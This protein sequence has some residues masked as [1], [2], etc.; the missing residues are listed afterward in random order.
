MARRKGQVQP[1]QM[2]G[3]RPGKAPPQ[4]RKKMAKQQMGEL[5]T[6]QER[7]VD[8]F[9]DRSP[10]AS[11]RLISRWITGTL[12]GGIALIVLSLL[13]WSWTW[14]AGVPVT[15]LAGGVLFS[16]LRLRKQR[17]QLEEMAEA[18]SKMTR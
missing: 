17:I 10:E 16:H 1:P 18:V 6:A 9:A 15:L 3:F 13:A 5:S 8:L 2:K 14:I 11:R 7:M 12:I 4:L